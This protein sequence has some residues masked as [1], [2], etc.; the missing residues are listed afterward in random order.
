MLLALGTQF[1]EGKGWPKR[2]E[3]RNGCEEKRGMGYHEIISSSSRYSLSNGTVSIDMVMI[4]DD[5]W[6]RKGDVS[7]DSSNES[8]ERVD[9]MN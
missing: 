6:I 2:E 4:E 7:T 8:C 9:L 5:V 3:E 1:L